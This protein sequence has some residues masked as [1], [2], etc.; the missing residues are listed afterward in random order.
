DDSGKEPTTTVE[1]YNSEHL[2]P[3]TDGEFAVEGYDDHFIV[4]KATDAD[5]STSA[6]VHRIQVRDTDLDPEE[7]FRHLG[8]V[9]T[10]GA[11][12]GDAGLSVATDVGIEKA[13]AKITPV[14]S[15]FDLG[16]K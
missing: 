16:A 15:F 4:I 5:G 7:V 2:L 14:G 6:K 11:E 1:V 12:P 3:V 13:W 9:A 8:T 10:V